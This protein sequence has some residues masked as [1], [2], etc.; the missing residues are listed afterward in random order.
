[1]NDKLFAR[2][3]AWRD[4]KYY[5]PGDKIITH[6]YVAFPSLSWGTIFVYQNA[7]S[8]TH[9]MTMRRFLLK[10]LVVNEFML[11]VNEDVYN[12]MGALC[13]ARE[14]RPYGLIQV[15]GKCLVWIC[16]WLGIAIE[17]PISEG[18]QETDCIEEQYTILTE[19]GYR[20]ELDLDSVSVKPYRDW[21]ASIPNIRE[22]T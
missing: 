6:G 4:S 21:V 10:N 14:G 17:N 2:L 18:D 8:G 12:R 9:F 15:F 19:A 11:E 13:V 1:M 16:S 5:R 7:G 22:L 3:I 20:S